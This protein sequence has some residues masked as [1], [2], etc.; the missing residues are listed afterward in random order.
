MLIGGTAPDS[1]KYRSADGGLA[2][3]DNVKHGDLLGG[4]AND[5]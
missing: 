2:T 3:G 5:V 1:A 4:T